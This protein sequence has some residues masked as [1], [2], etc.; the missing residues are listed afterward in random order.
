VRDRLVIVTP[1][2]D[3]HCI[4]LL[5]KNKLDIAVQYAFRHYAFTAP[6]NHFS[7]IV[8]NYKFKNYH[9]MTCYKID[10]VATL[11][12]SWIW[13][14]GHLGPLDFFFVDYINNYACID[15]MQNQ[16]YI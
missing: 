9:S 7:T 16:N 2:E 1:Q 5:D 14:S 12:G 15:K 11:P 10:F 4:L 3:E 6:G 8:C 13:K